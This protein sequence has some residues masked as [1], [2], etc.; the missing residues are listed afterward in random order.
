MI[1][2]ISFIAQAVPVTP[3]EPGAESAI[4]WNTV[5]LGILSFLGTAVSGIIAVFMVKVQSSAALAEK[6]ADVAATR[7]AEVKSDL[8]QSTTATNGK[9][10]VIHALSNSAL[11]ASMK[12]DEASQTI[13]LMMMEEMLDLK[14]ERG[15][16][17]SEEAIE[18][19]AK[20]KGRVEELR[21]AIVERERQQ[22]LI[23]ERIAE[24]QKAGPTQVIV[25]NTETKPVPVIPADS[26]I[27]K[28][29]P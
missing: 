19:L 15:S 18:M 25:V 6:A 1:D 23:D 10:D 9:L 14:K 20:A 3:V 2:F 29:I 24:G 26:P 4:N 28:V 16:E 17:A 11:T 12:S 22:G 21:R 5:I 7:V 27:T 8:I 13:N